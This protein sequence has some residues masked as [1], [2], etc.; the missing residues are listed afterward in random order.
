MG[1]RP[2]AAVP[3]R[4]RGRGERDTTERWY[5]CCEDA[6]LTTQ[7]PGHAPDVYVPPNSTCVIRVNA[8][9]QRCATIPT[10]CADTA[11][12]MRSRRSA[13]SWRNCASWATPTRISRRF[14]SRVSHWSN[15]DA[16]FFPNTMFGLGRRPGSNMVVCTSGRRTV[17]FG[18]R[19][20]G[21]GIR[22]PSDGTCTPVVLVRRQ[23]GVP[24]CGQASTVSTEMEMSSFIRSPSVLLR[25]LGG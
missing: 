10:S 5:Q 14:S 4:M 17:P 22:T 3:T 25:W 16:A 9:P 1:A 24:C 11:R 13:S 21:A 7:M 8:T 18:Y 12:R 19:T 6:G 23:T 15:G 20:C 2:V